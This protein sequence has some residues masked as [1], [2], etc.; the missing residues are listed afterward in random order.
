MPDKP[1]KELN[2]KIGNIIKNRRKSLGLSQQAVADYMNVSK[3]AISRWESGQVDNMGRSRIQ[4]LSGVLNIS[5]ASIVLGKEV[6]NDNILPFQT[7]KVPILGK[8]AAG[9]PILC[10]EETEAYILVNEDLHIDYCLKVEGDSMI[11]ARIHDG[12]LVF[13]RQQPVVENGEIAVVLIDNEVT[14]KRFYKDKNLIMLKP[15][16]SKYKP[17]MYTKEDFKQVRILGK[18]IFFQSK[19]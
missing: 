7:K 13:I 19:L 12:D 16:N 18:A 5:P 10:N 1:N 17:L 9:E 8:I 3:S 4:Q 11:E 6:K 14:L 2:K 15:E